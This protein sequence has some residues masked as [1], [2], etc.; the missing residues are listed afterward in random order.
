MRFG[1]VHFYDLLTFNR[2]IAVV[3]PYSGVSLNADTIWHFNDHKQAHYDLFNVRYVVAPRKWTPP[4]FLRPIKETRRYVLYEAPTKG[5]GE[6]VAI[7]DRE[8]PASQSAMFFRSRNWML[9]P[10]PEA[11]RYLRYDYPAAS[12]AGSAGASDRRDAAASGCPGGKTSDE[13]VGPGWIAMR[14]ECP[15]A[16]TLVLKQTY[17]PN[18]E[19]TVDGRS[20]PAF[21][22]SPSFIGVSVPGG[23]HEVRAEYRPGVLKTG[24]LILGGLTAVAV[25][26]FRRRFAD[27][28]KRWAPA[29]A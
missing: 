28:E 4:P 9:G 14:V 13:R 19:I 12:G 2:I 6:L 1:D 11:G 21:M 16:S 15:T 25:V 5:Y 17:H 8:A 26:V 7:A 10:D 23:T 3:P 22:V 29:A 18:W 27:L 24:L 20:A